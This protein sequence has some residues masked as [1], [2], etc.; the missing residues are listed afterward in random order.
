M[1]VGA[2][3]KD[4]RPGRQ[5][6][7]MGDK[8]GNKREKQPSLKRALPTCILSSELNIACSIKGEGRVRLKDCILHQLSQA[9]CTWHIKITDKS[10]PTAVEIDIE[11]R[12]NNLRTCSTCFFHEEVSRDCL[13]ELKIQPIEWNQLPFLEFISESVLFWA[14]VSEG[15][16]FATW[17]SK[18]SKKLP[19]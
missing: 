4:M 3:R 19:Q 16:Q 7:N 12:S 8:M 10:F 5:Q 15:W 13:N 14:S 11:I 18:Q 2:G 17:G 6:R 1:A 9:Y